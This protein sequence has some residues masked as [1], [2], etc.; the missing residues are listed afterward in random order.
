MKKQVLFFLLI[1][2]FIPAL[3]S[4]ADKPRYDLKIGAGFLNGDTTYQIGGKT[5]YSNGSTE[6]IQFPLSELE[7][8]I[9]T[10][11]LSINS[12]IEFS[13]QLTGNLGFKTSIYDD[14][15]KLKDSDWGVWHIGGE[16]PH[17]SSTCSPALC[18]VDSLD[19]FSE[20]D[21]TLDAFIFDI[22]LR[23]KVLSKKSN[24]TALDLF[25]GLGYRYENFEY[26]VSDLD[27]WYPS[28]ENYFGF[29]FGHE[30]VSG[31]V[32]T[33][34]VTYNIIYIEVGAAVDL[35]NRIGID[36]SI[37]YSPLVLV[38]DRD[39]HVLRDKISKGD[40]DG[41]AILYSINLS[42][43]LV[44]NWFSTINFNYTRIE[45]DGE[46]KQYFSNI[47]Y[48]TIDEEVTSSQTSAFIHLGYSFN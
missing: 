3:L 29:D 30:F 1:L 20:S 40:L 41:H 13:P 38:H 35:F 27:Q 31:T 34:E 21:T 16:L 10:Y 11:M 48:A 24:K 19:I 8:P 18:T 45:T 25:A 7:F 14:S 28:F 6:T 47:F 33:Y 37:G 22:N 9:N 12:T 32:L 43:H 17:N 42:G 23:Y 4:A 5:I 15:G 46:Q 36:A 39:N 26:K 2:F 44:G